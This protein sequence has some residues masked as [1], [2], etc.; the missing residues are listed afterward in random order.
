[1]GEMDMRPSRLIF[2]FLSGGIVFSYLLG[3][4]ALALMLAIF[5]TFLIAVSLLG[6][7]ARGEAESAREENQSHE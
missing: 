3:A 7:W 1:M 6:S 4:P 2:A 5:L